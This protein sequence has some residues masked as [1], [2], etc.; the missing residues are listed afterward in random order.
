MA[1]IVGTLPAEAFL[2]GLSRT[3]RVFPLLLKGHRPMALLPR[4][5]WGEREEDQGLPGVDRNFEVMILDDP[6]SPQAAP[7]SWTEWITQ[8]FSWA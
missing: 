8:M 1:D 7:Q 2:S 6:R 5:G 4:G 3:L